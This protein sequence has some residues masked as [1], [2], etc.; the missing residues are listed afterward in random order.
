MSD[1]RV[2]IADWL[3]SDEGR[4]LEAAKL[5]A[6]LGRRLNAAGVPVWR[7]HVGSRTMHPE[8]YVRFYDWYEGA[9]AAEEK[10]LP[11]SI[12]QTL[13]TTAATGLC[14]TSRSSARR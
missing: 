12:S 4:S 3:L 9:E 8:V 11:H 13:A 1:A 14:V 10:T 2:E 6:E 7:L 5:I